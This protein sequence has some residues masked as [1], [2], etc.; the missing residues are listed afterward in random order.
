RDQQALGAN[1]AVAAAPRLLAGGDIRPPRVE[2][3]LALCFR[4]PLRHRGPFR[5]LV[6][7]DWRVTPS[8]SPIC[9]HDHPCPRAS[10]HCAASTRSARRLNANTARNPTAGSPVESTAE[11]STGPRSVSST[12]VSLD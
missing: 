12:S 6:W 11:R 3:G 7:I 8:A 9:C 10:A 5:C 4:L 2:D 1:A